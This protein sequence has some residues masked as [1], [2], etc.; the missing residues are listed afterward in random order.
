[1]IKKIIL[2]L[3]VA[4]FCVATIFA[5]NRR[6]YDDA[7]R[8]VGSFTELDLEG[9]CDL[10]LIKGDSCSVEIDARNNYNDYRIITKV[11]GNTLCVYYE[12]DWFM[13]RG[14]FFRPFP[15]YSIYITY[16]ELDEIDLEGRIRLNV[17]APLEADDLEIDM[18]G[19][20]TGEFTVNAKH[21]ELDTEG[22]VRL[23]VDGETVSQEIYMEGLGRIDAR[24]LFTDFCRVDIDG[25]TTLDIY[26]REELDA[27][28]GGVS[29]LN[30][31]GEPIH[32]RID[33]DGWVRV[34][35][36]R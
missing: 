13:D 36:C 15:R 2:T 23:R 5:Q 16:T 22:F 3:L 14:S 11:R 27:D 24:D 25:S 35:S 29:T 32:K 33:R 30:Y 34:R 28:I 17:D 7:F 26:V 1:M 20:I 12:D 18:S 6:Y 8:N 19:Y 10:Y 31:S 9:N 4:L 21:L